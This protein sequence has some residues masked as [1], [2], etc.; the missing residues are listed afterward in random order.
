MKRTERV[1]ILVADETAQVDVD[2]LICN[3][4]G[5]K[6]LAA[7]ATERAWV[8]VES[9]GRGGN[10]VHFCGPAH[11]IEYFRELMPREL[12]ERP[13]LTVIAGGHGESVDPAS[14]G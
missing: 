10:H 7:R 14:A 9:D 8:A 11:A 2:V 5:T 4:C 13:Q 12:S 1:S 3:R 6:V